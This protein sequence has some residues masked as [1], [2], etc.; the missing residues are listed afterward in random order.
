M[1]HVHA[2][3]RE[4]DRE[5]Q[6]SGR[7]Y[8]LTPR[9]RRLAIAYARQYPELLRRRTEILHGGGTGTGGSHEVS[10]P[11]A[12]KG[13]RL[14]QV[15]EKIRAIE[16]AIERIPKEYR[17]GVLDNVLFGVSRYR[18]ET[19]GH[20][21]EATWQRQRERFLFYVALFCKIR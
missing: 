20:A 2:Q 21:G 15:E 1:P 3:G 13:I 5:A 6:M 12:I 9:R 17:Q 18:L 7:G 19:K 14:T 11:T 4:A 8:K 16:K 10:D